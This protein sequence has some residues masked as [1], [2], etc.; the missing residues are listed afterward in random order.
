VIADELAFWSRDDGA[1]PTS[2]VLNAVRP[3]LATLN[4][5][6]VG[7]SSPFA[8]SGRLWDVYDRYFGPKPIPTI[9]GPQHSWRWSD[10]SCIEFRAP[11]FDCHSTANLHSRLPY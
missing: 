8:K 4:G 1:N 11:S 3:G 2:E 10:Q 7:I 6:L 9:P 5:Q